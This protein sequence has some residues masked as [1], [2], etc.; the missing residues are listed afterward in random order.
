MANNRRGHK[1]KPKQPLHKRITPSR[2]FPIKGST[3]VPKGKEYLGNEDSSVNNGTSNK[4]VQDESMSKNRGGDTGGLLTSNN[5]RE[6]RKDLQLVERAVRSGW[7]IKRK[8]MIKRRLLEIMEKTHV[9]VPTKMGT[10]DVDGPADSNAI[11]AARV[12][13]AMN[14]QDQSD[15]HL[16]IKHQAEQPNTVVNIH[17]NNVTTIDNRRIELARLAKSLGASELSI[18]GR[19]VSVDDVI[20]SDVVVPKTEAPTR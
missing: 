8:N 9:S 17:N 12:L 20:E 11:A 7:N 4:K 18:S 3:K 10:V 19:T 6:V 15:D 2:K 13:V 5:T 16:A 1:S 14:G